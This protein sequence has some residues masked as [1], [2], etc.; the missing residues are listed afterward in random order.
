MDENTTI[1]PPIWFWMATA[2]ALIWNLMGVAA[3][4]AGLA[5]DPVSPAGPSEDIVQPPFW[6]T[7]AF[8][9]AVF[10]GAVGCIALSLRSARALWLFVLSLIGIILQQIYHFV[11][12]DIGQNLGTFDLVMTV[13]IPV[14]GALLIWL[15]RSAATKGWLR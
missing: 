5:T 6:Y 4:V 13:M 14:V 7:V 15:A 8:G 12:S 2:V 11:L 3:F 10:G 1:K 9:L